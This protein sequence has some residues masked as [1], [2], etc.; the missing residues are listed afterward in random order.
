MKYYLSGHIIPDNKDDDLNI[1]Q[2]KQHFEDIEKKLEYKNVTVL[3]PFTELK[4]IY[5]EKISDF[6]DMRFIL[7]NKCDVVYMIAG[8]EQSKDAKL[9]HAYASMR[10]MKIE[11]EEK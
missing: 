10:G 9:E 3:N 1:P 6:M 7:I 4:D 5:V 2:I 8:W 11:Y